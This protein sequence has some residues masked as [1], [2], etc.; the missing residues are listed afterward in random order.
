MQHGVAPNG[1]NGPDLITQFLKMQGNNPTKL[2]VIK[3]NM[4]QYQMRNQDL[5]SR[6][7]NK[8]RNHTDA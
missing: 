5:N 1:Y 4:N 2:G 3:D 7:D 8:Q 6:I